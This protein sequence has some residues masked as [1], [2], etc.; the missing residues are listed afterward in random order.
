[1]VNTLLVLLLA[2]WPLHTIVPVQPLAVRLAT[3]PAHRV[4]LL[5][6]IVVGG[7][8]RTV[9]EA[10]VKQPG[11]VIHVA[12]YVLLVWLAVAVTM[13]PEPDTLLLQVKAPPVQPLAVSVIVFPCVTVRLGVT[14][15]A[16]EGFGNT[17]NVVDASVIVWQ[18]GSLGI[19]FRHAYITY[20]VETD[21]ELVG[22][23]VVLMVI[24]AVPLVTSASAM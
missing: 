24:Q 23:A 17:V 20:V 1:M 14:A 22:T 3:L 5:T 4:A 8:A 7:T 9:I 2:P 11:P 13:L 15:N 16:N 21:P 10:V 19:G 12:E 6:C 18:F